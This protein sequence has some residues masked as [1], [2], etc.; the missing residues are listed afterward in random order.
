ME[1]Q[2]CPQARRLESGKPVRLSQKKMNKG[3]G[4]EIKITR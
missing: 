4:F 3:E 1:R 2:T